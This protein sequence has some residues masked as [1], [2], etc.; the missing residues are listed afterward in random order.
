LARRLQL[1]WQRLEG[2][3]QMQSTM[4]DRIMRGIWAVCGLAAG[5]A[6]ALQPGKREVR[7]MVLPGNSGYIRYE[8]LPGDDDLPPGEMTVIHK[9]APP[10]PP[11]DTQAQTQATTQT[12]AEAAPNDSPQTRRRMAERQRQRALCAP[13]RGKLAARLLE[14][15]GL[16]VDPGFAEWLTHNVTIGS[17]G[18]AELQLIGPDPLLYEAV[19]NDLIARSLAEDLAQCQSAAR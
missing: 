13:I 17:E 10:A 8:V 7:T 9:D 12:Q 18:V 15:R 1:E 4:K 19:R 11:A 16:E 5:A 6:F 3:T 2:E 14:L